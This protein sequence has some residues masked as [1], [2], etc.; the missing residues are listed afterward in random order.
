[1]IIFQLLRGHTDTK[2]HGQER[3]QYPLGSAYVAEQK[4]YPL[5]SA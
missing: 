3:K 2:T 4:Q 1:M 5:R